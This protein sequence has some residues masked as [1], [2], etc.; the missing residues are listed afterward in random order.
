MPKCGDTRLKWFR[1][2]HEIVKRPVSPLRDEKEMDCLT[3]SLIRDGT[4]RYASSQRLHSTMNRKPWCIC[5]TRHPLVRQKSLRAFRSS[6]R[7]TT[8][9]YI[10]IIS[11]RT[12][13][14]PKNKLLSKQHLSKKKKY[15]HK[16]S[17]FHQTTSTISRFDRKIILSNIHCVM[18]YIR[19][20]D[21]SKRKREKND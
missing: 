15:I 2:P 13:A 16:S 11:K 5:R 20:S 7:L 10:W 12:F 19:S 18:I 9:E 14:I 21:K 4:P 8:I 17:L 6:P 1:I 3:A